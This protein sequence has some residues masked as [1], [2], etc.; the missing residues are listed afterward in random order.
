MRST[1]GGPRDSDIQGMSTA[2]NVRLP[3]DGPVVLDGLGRAPAEG[4]GRRERRRIGLQGI[5]RRAVDQ[6]LEHEAGLTQERQ[7]LAAQLHDL[8]MQDV[9][10]ALA[11]SRAIAGDPSLAR[12]HANE[13]V[14]ACERALA[15]A[16]EMLD[17]LAKPGRAL[18]RPSFVD[19][20]RL[21]ARDVPLTLE[22]P[23]DVAGEPDRVTAEAL[24][25]IGREAVT[26]AVKHARPVLVD[27]ALARDDEW[28]LTVT[29]DGRGFDPVQA[30]P[31][32][33]LASLRRTVEGLG[34]SYSIA[35][36]P[37]RG[38]RIEVALP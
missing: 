26:N 34:G 36:A 11:R 10:F 33:G 38:T 5:G 17:G 35:S 12:K 15:G 24:V 7:R 37:G 20:V 14:A 21:A 19:S 22:L 28:R 1:A 16:R 31:G 13:A 8:V 9:A 27:V 23:P 3:L 6:Q 2:Q 30:D 32:F 25:H 29:D 18:L 4:C